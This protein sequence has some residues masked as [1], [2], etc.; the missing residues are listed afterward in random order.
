[1][2][3]LKNAK[4]ERFAQAVAKGMSA[5]E[6]YRLHV[7]KGAASQTV[8]TNGPKLARAAQ[9]KLRIAEI[10]DSNAKAVESRLAMTRE[11][12]LEKLEEISGNAD[13]SSAAVAALREI[14]KACAWYEPEKH[15]LE[16][17]VTI[18]GQ[19]AN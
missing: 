5:A 4:H 1:M 15:E 8:E 16:I 2:P 9:V 7:T 18:G 3:V 17:S 6:A 11:K 12:W 10:Q 19:A 13:S 14:G